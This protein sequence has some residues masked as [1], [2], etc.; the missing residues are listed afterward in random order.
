VGGN[1]VAYERRGRALIPSLLFLAGFLAVFMALGASAS[2]LGTV[3]AAH[4]HTFNVAAGVFV[5]AM[6]VLMVGDVALTGLGIGAAGLA[7]QRVAASRGGPVAL[8][9]AFAFCWTPCIGP[10]LGSILVLASAKLTLAQG[11]LLLLMY[12]LGLAVPFLLVSLSFTKAMRSFRLLR[13]F[14]RGFQG[15]ADPGRASRPSC[16]PRS[17]SS[18]TSTAASSAAGCA[19]RSSTPASTGRERWRATSGWCSRTRSRS[20]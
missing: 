13:R 6:G 16:G 10:V 2:E 15:W 18:R 20:S 19:S 9:V 7:V 8:G 1:P 3:L 17:A 4:R 11:V 14:Y 5:G 12:G